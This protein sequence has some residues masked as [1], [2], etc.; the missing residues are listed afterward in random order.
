VSP[1]GSA[2]SSELARLHAYGVLNARVGVRGESE[3]VDWSASLWTNNALDD[4]YFTSLSRGS[5]GEYNGQRGLP[6][7][8][9]ITLRVD[10]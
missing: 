1:N 2:D 3:K 6:R 7:A 5:Y 4:T 10:F 8:Y 9:G